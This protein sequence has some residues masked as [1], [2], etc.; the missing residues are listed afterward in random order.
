M[1]DD[2][3]LLDKAK[4]T[5][6]CQRN[7]KL[8][9]RYFLEMLLC[10][11]FSADQE[12]L[13]GH[14]LDLKLNR[15]V[16]IKKQSIHSKF[17][18]KAVNFLK[19]LVSIQLSRKLSVP[20]KILDMFSSVLIHDST[21]FGLPESFTEHYAGY[22]GRGAPAGAKIQF[23]YDLKTHQ[24][25]HAIL[26]ASRVND[27]TDCKSNEWITKGA[28]V[29]RDLGYYSHEGLKEIIDK[30]AFFISKVKPKTALFDLCGQRLDL[31]KLIA[32][33]KKSGLLTLERDL[34][35]GLE[36]RFKARVVFALMPDEIKNKRLKAVTYKAQNRN[37]TVQKEYKV[38]AGINVFITNVSKECLTAEK[39][40]QIYRLRWQVE[41]VFKTWKS[42]YRID[43]YKTMR[44]ERMEC[45]LFATLLLILLQWKIF[46]WLNRHS[47]QKGIPLSLH[48]FTMLM[49]RLKPLFN[50]TVVRAKADMEILLKH[51][52]T[53]SDAYLLKENKKGKVN[54]MDIVSIKS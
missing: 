34:L 22:G 26:G 51:I 28:L 33:M 6:F 43:C 45:Y 19:V 12:S 9:P 5:G 7:R 18:D 3:V 50:E 13:L 2:D 24:V 23:A 17:T 15:D 46:S 42:H 49:I 11:C 31:P 10:K 29:L 16:D 27:L 4:E 39:I 1:L 47:L 40:M 54:F 36:G 53:L 37:S 52:M 32:S 41:L 20:S 35:V 14:A 8:S 48:K 44:K 25:C 21:R 30:E 38:W